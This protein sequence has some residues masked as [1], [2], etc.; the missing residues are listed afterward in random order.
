MVWTYAGDPRNDVTD[1]VK[2]MVGD[3]DAADPLAQ[4]AEVDYALAVYPKPE[5]KAPYLAAAM[6]CD[7]I[8]A[9]F[10]RRA[11][12]S[13]GSLSIAANQQYEHYVAEAARLRYAYATDGRGVGG[14]FSTVKPAAPVLGGGGTTFLGGRGL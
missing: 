3:T 2:W 8:A 13:V 10:A 12:R 4:D 7:G 1:E 5:G 6:V 14:G 9:K 11:Q